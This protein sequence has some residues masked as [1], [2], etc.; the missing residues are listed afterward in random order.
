MKNNTRSAWLYPSVVFT[1]ILGIILASL[2]AQQTYQLENKQLITDFKRVSDNQAN[3]LRQ[4]IELNLEVLQ[5]IESFFNGSSFVSRQE[6][7]AFTQKSLLRHPS[8][9]ALEWIPRI[10]HKE[11]DLYEKRAREEGLDGFTLTQRASQGVMVAALPRE[12]Y[13]PVYYV[14]PIAKNRAAIGFDLASDTLRR[15]ALNQA[16]DSGNRLAT[17]GITLV[18]ETEKQPGFLVFIPIYRG[19]S[20]S[21]EARRENLTGFALGVYRIGEMAV[22]A[23]AQIDGGDFSP[24]Q[25]IWDVTQPKQPEA[26]FPT[27]LLADEQQLIAQAKARGLYNERFIEIGSR[28]WVIQSIPTADHLFNYQRQIKALVVFAVFLLF[29]LL[30]AAYIKQRISELLSNREQTQAIVQTAVF[31][32]ITIN[33]KGMVLSYNPASE[34]IFG[35]T[36]EEVIGRNVKMLMPE[37]TASAHDG[38]LIRHLKT[39][40]NT[41]IGNS[42]EVEG[43]RK[44]GS[45]FPMWLAVGKS[46]TS[47]GVFFAGCVVDISVKKRANAENKKLLLALEQSPNPVLI[48]D[49]QGVIEYVNPAMERQTGH[50]RETL[51][52]ST[53]GMLNSGLTPEKLYQEMWQTI[54]SGEIWRGE[55]QNRCQDGS[56]YWASLNISPLRDE[57]GVITHY[58]SQQEDITDRKAVES[59]L[60]EAKIAAEKANQAKSDFLNV[61]S[62][63][64]RTP[65][66]VVLGNAPFIT[67]LKDISL[68]PDEK[69]LPTIKKLAEALNSDHPDVHEIRQSCLALFKQLSGFGGKIEKQ[70]KHLKNLIDDLLDISKIEAGKMVLTPS[71]LDALVLVKNVMIDMQVKA[72]EKGTTLSCSGDSSPLVAD[73]IR[74]KQI[75]IN[76]IGNAIKFTSQGRIQIHLEQDATSTT[77]KIEDSGSGIP[78]SQ[79][80]LI[81]DKFVQADS[82]TT[83]KVGGSGLGLAIT[84]RLIELHGGTITVE[85]QEGVGTTFTF[86][87]PNA[88]T[89]K[90]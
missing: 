67:M 43:Q 40:K 30:V 53:P 71:S 7:F 21:I 66:T 25:F 60:I 15:T 47:Q 62:H 51:L 82:T 76:L 88:I 52:G 10:F 80:T 86:T 18:Q 8:I 9:Q 70:G 13:F 11:R 12:V 90:R 32:M 31:G 44:D 1:L 55:I 74:L 34:K 39:G 56:I 49:P 37:T 85:S 75:L 65:L 5:A 79:L 77:F 54:S 28:R 26:L 19:P 84:K 48:T 2:A 36:A 59:A 73:E 27:T 4:E 58:I 89:Q 14:E 41:I 23:F 63:E 78:A 50:A 46:Q 68:E 24:Q 72:D 57:K 81:F 45:L 16:R 29:T 42:R 83:R 61:M 38:Y 64:L 3:A 20:H 33:A 17:G 69:G 87:L 22:N 35:Y 6:F